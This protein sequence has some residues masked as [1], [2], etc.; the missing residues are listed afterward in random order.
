MTALNQSS[1]AWVS[2]RQGTGLNPACST[3]VR[4][5]PSLSDGTSAA[6]VANFGGREDA[7]GMELVERSELGDGSA[8]GHQA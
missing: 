7:P 3:A 1:A 5:S 2:S 4:V 8:S 6:A